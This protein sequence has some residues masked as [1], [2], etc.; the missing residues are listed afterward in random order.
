MRL[1]T[2]AAV[3]AGTRSTVVLMEKLLLRLNSQ[4]MI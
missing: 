2:S 1:F 3:W 4:A